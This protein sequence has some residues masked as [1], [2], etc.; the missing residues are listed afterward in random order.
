M[1][2][3][4]PNEYPE[5]NATVELAAEVAF[6]PAVFAAVAFATLSGAVGHV[7]AREAFDCSSGLSWPLRRLTVNLAPLKVSK[8]VNTA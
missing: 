6:F 5:G 2:E 1:R 7:V 3:G 8:M 4:Y